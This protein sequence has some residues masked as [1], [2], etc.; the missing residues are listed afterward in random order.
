[1]KRRDTP[2]TRNKGDG[3]TEFTRDHRMPIEARVT[4]STPRPLGTLGCWVDEHT[5]RAKGAPRPFDTSLSNLNEQETKKKMMQ[6]R[7]LERK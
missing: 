1:M 6:K 3:L 2:G 5:V 7:S 4:E